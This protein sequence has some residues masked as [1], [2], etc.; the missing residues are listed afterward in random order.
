[1]NEQDTLLKNYERINML[2]EQYIDKFTKQNMPDLANRWK[3]ILINYRR[4]VHL[5][6][7][8]QS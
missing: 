7:H 3:N 8:G 4:A 5:K 6:V 2:F 1:M